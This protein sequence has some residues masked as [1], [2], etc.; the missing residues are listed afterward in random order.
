MDYG[1]MM[2]E[3]ELEEAARQGTIWLRWA[4]VG[5]VIIVL[6]RIFILHVPVE[7]IPCP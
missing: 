7:A 4:L 6:A 3:E 2:S 5:F 1:F